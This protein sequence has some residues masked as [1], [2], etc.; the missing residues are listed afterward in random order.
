MAPETFLRVL[1]PESWRVAYLQP[2][3]RPADGRYGENPHRLIKHTQMQVIL[4]PPP[5]DTQDVYLASL[6]NLGIDLRRALIRT[7]EQHAERRFLTVPL[8][9]AL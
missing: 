7:M 6:N 9:E 4:K 1:G 8:L 3:R 5:R 2:S